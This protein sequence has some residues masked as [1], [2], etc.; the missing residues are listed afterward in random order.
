MTTLSDR[1][2]NEGV[3]PSTKERQGS[4]WQGPY[5]QGSNGGITYSLLSRFLVCRERFHIYAIDGLRPNPSFNHKI[6]FGSMWHLCEESL[7]KSGGAVG[8]A[9]QEVW[10]SPLTDYAKGL[11]KRFPTQ[12]EEIDKWYRICALMFPKYVSYWEN[13]SDVKDR[14]PLLQEKVFDVPYLL[15]DGRVVRLRGKWDSVDLIGKGK[16]TSIYLQENKTKGDINEVIMQRNLRSGFDL[17]TMIYLVTLDKW[18]N[19]GGFSLSVAYDGD[20]GPIIGGIRYN[21]VRRPLHRQGKKETKTEFLIRLGEV[22]DE[23]P[24]HF[25]MR[26]KVGIL[27]QDISRFRKETLD[28]ILEQLCDWWSLAISGPPISFRKST[29]FGP[30]HWRHPFGVYNPI[31]EGGQSDLDEHLLTGSTV[32]LVR[33]DSLFEE[34]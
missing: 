32:G 5:Y 34:L 24:P 31:D 11:C 27:A 9:G 8:Y 23:D 26:W 6:E 19:E 17:Q 7:L 25:F 29:M 12:Q 21:V 13:H 1:L 10:V 3:D 16:E 2:R 18:I 14:I 30:L 33:A 28:P 4:L 15:P 22:I 20:H